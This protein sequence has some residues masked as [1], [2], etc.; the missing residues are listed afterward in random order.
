MITSILTLLRPHHYIKNSFIF[1]PLF[2]GL[3]VFE[4]HLIYQ[5]LLSFIGFSSIA[6]AVYI[7]NDTLDIKLDQ[8]HPIKKYRPLASGSVPLKLAFFLA[9]LLLLF[10]FSI[11]IFQQIAFIFLFYVLLNIVYSLKLKHIP[12]ID[13]FIIAIGFVIRLFIGATVTSVEL[14]IWIVIMTFLLALF[15]AF[16]KRKC[17]LVSL[18]GT[19]NARPVLVSYNHEFLSTCMAIMASVVIVSYIMYTTS[20]SVLASTNSDYVYFTS[21]FVLFGI[22]RYLSITYFEKT[23]D[24]PTKILLHD[25]WL[26]L[27]II[28]WLI[29]F[30]VMLY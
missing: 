6:S 26:Q 11:A 23:T 13:V 5:L 22:L 1:L 2:F 25:I 18:K 12:I 24:N 28:G 30:A 27:S 3:K 9:T 21:I 4:L 7:F 19:S 20:S 29:S 16:S 10:G 8:N 17:D 14:S 15:L